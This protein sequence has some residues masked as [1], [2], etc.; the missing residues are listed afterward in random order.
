MFHQSALSL[1]FV[2]ISPLVSGHSMV[3]PKRVVPRLSDL[4]P[5]EEA[6]LW[7]SVREVQRILALVLHGGAGG[8][9]GGGSAGGDATAAQAAAQEEMSFQLGVQDGPVAGQSVPHVHV[10]ILPMTR[11]PSRP[12]SQ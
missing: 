5:E 4:T 12:S 7:R 3:I 10:H 11:P 6:D 8:G 2:N 9:G 1:A